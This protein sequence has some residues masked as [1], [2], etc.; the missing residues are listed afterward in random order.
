MRQFHTCQQNPPGSG[1]GGFLRL[2]AIM[3]KS[4]GGRRKGGRG[5]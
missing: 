5:Y 3:A 1:L 2:E 4:K